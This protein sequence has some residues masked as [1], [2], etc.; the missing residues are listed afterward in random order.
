MIIFDFRS[1]C[2]LWLGGWV[3]FFFLTHRKNK[4]PCCAHSPD[5]HSPDVHSPDVH[6]PDVPHDNFWAS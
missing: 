2:G 3:V 6:S 5:V 1:V 4:A